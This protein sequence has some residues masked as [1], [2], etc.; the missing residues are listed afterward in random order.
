[1]TT[2]NTALEQYRQGDLDERHR[3]A[4]ALATAGDLI[5]KAL[6]AAPTDEAGN[7][8]P[9]PL[10]PSAGKVL[11]VLETGAMLGLPP[12]A[13]LQGIQ[14]IEGKA[15]LSAGMMSAVVR[16][17]GHLLHVT[18]EGTVE[19]GD[20]RTTATLVRADDKDHP[21]TSV[22]TP[23]KAARAGLCAYREEGGVWRVI[24]QSSNGSPKPW[25]A[26]TEAMLRSRAIA[27]VCRMGAEDALYGVHYTPEELAEGPREEQAVAHVAEPE[28]E[29]EVKAEAKP[30]R[31]AAVGKQ[32]TKRPADEPAPEEPKPEEVV[33]AEVVEH[34]E[35]SAPLH[36][37]PEPE[38]TEP[39]VPM[40][41]EEVSDVPPADAPTDDSD[42]P[43]EDD[44]SLQAPEVVD[45][46]T[47][48]IYA[49]REELEAAKAT[50]ES[51]EDRLKAATTVAQVKAVW[52][53][54][55]G[56]PALTTDLRMAI[57]ARKAEVEA[58]QAKREQAQA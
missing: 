24:A 31:R 1:M 16:R 32:G 11:L 12:V 34:D 39:E 56:T 30:R 29:P 18:E 10:V 2:D 7:R 58:E 44:Y 50:P 6:H 52:D 55:S 43:P 51:W 26:Y 15:T 28:Q 17:A 33:E 9:G 5:P 19:R 53:A 42:V 25:Q 57:I 48:T 8:L 22:W 14:V 45:E 21:F 40:Y 35:P 37:E 54:T 49:S 36:P 41:A 20:L 13:A 23:H 46:N 3:F 4:R 27:E 47:G 38:T